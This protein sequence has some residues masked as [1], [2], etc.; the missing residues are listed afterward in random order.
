MERLLPTIFPAI[1]D[2][3]PRL[4]HSPRMPVFLHIP[5]R[6]RLRH[7]CS[8]ARNPRQ[9]IV[10]TIAAFSERPGIAV[11]DESRG[12]IDP[13]TRADYDVHDD[14]AVVAF[15]LTMSAPTD[16]R[17]YLCGYVC[18]RTVTARSSA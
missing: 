12:G 17:F 4:R 5:S 1:F 11:A 14:F 8:S 15:A 13:G 10:G 3:S 16:R 9:P 18:R 7:A 6:N 2:W